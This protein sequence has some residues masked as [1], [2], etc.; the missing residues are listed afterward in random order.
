M[1]TYTEKEVEK[2]KEQ[3]YG[4]GERAILTRQ[5]REIIRGLG[6]P[7]EKEGRHR[8]ALIIEREEAIASLRSL[9]EVLGDNHWGED[10]HLADIINNHIRR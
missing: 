8:N 2:I 10:L 4:Q 1:K 7:K 9:C 5:L 6:Y 3:Y